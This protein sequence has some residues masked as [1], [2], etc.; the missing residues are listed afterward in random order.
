MISHELMLELTRAMPHKLILVNGKPYL[1]RYYAGTFSDERDLWFHHFHSADGDRHVHSHPFSF[2]TTVLHGWYREEIHNDGDDFYDL[3]SVASHL[4]GERYL[5]AAVKE[6][7]NGGPS[8]VC[9]GLHR[10][11]D[12]WH[13]IAEVAPNTWTM[14]VVDPAR[15]D[16]WHFRG[17]DGS[18]KA[19]KSSGR[20]WWKDYGPRQS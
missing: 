10:Q 20:F 13:R 1:S 19:E 4:A 5:I 17:P 2:T 8:C 16:E 6:A 3:I 14:V 18:L 7:M 9:V 12:H 15:R 11:A